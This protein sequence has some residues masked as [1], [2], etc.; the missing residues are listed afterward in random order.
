MSL[1]ALRS[2]TNESTPVI[3]KVKSLL[4]IGIQLDDQIATRF[5]TTLAN[6][7]Q[8]VRT[9]F[10][11]SRWNIIDG[12]R[13]ERTMLDACEYYSIDETIM[14][15]TIVVVDAIRQNSLPRNDVEFLSLD[16]MQDYYG[17]GRSQLTLYRKRQRD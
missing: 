3:D 14:F 5:D 2:V 1:Q 8:L 10:D 7:K 4:E 17:I 6:L 11:Q 13:G 12:K 16:S 15:R 9:C